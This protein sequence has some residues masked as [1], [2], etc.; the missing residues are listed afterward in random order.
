MTVE[1]QKPFVSD[2]IL[3]T[4][5]GGTGPDVIM[6]NGSGGTPS[7]WQGTVTA[8]PDYRY[9]LIQ[10]KGFAGFPAKA[11][12][13]GPLLKPLADEIIRY[14]SVQKL[15]RPTIVGFSMGGTLALLVA[16]RAPESISRLVV[17]DQLPFEGVRII[18]PGSSIDDLR[19]LA[20]NVVKKILKDIEE[21]TTFPSQVDPQLAISRGWPVKD[22]ALRPIIFEER[23]A[24]DPDVLF[25]NFNE[26]LLTDLTGDMRL[27]SAETAV[28]Y[29]TR[30]RYYTDDE[31]DEVYRTAYAGIPNAKMLRIP[32][33]DH[34]IMNDNPSRFY[35]EFREILG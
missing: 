3:V 30:G 13:T 5:E 2:R 21:T 26:L 25:T 11:N 8:L 20:D 29:V 22:E 14:I 10:I 31:M 6:L 34:F 15:D 9:H 27:I 7:V 32:D 28:L 17:V 18:Q 23:K 1:D 16:S 19:P 4:I 24:S 12:K 35:T 33:S